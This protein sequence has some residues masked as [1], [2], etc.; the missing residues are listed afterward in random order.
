MGVFLSGAFLGMESLDYEER[1]A[2]LRLDKAVPD[3]FPKWWCQCQFLCSVFKSPHC[4]TSL[5]VFAIADF[6]ILTMHIF[7]S[8]SEVVSLPFG[9]PCR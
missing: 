2:Q 1:D 4:V 8:P 7:L 3:C 9:F 5:P 6:R